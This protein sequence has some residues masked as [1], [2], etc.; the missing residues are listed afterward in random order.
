VSSYV[1]SKTYETIFEMFLIISLSL[2]MFTLENLIKNF[3]QILIFSYDDIKYLWLSMEMEF[4]KEVWCL[5]MSLSSP[6]I[7]NVLPT[8]IDWI[9]RTGFRIWSNSIFKVSESD[10][11]WNDF[12]GVLP[13]I[14]IWTSFL[15]KNFTFGPQL[16][17]L[18]WKL[19]RF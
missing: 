3:P 16:T 14:S 8:S 2:Q 9:L 19:W 5:K 10:W 6:S 4:Q 11:D 17:I 1:F 7:R 15:R 12:L 13:L 18:F